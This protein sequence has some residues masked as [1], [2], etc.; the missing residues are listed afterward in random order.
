[1]PYATPAYPAIRDAILRDVAN[2]QPDA[3]VGPDS[4][5]YI[6]AAGIAAAV[7]GLYMH[8]DWLSRQILPDLADA[9][10]LE[11]H[12]SLRGMTRKPAAYA[13]GTLTFSGTPGASIPIGTQARTVAG[14]VYATTL[15]AA[16][17]GAGAATLAAQA[18][19]PGAA[20][21]LVTGASLTLVSAPSGVNGTAIGSAMTGGADIETDAE[22]RTRLI[23]LIRNPPSG[24]AAHDYVRWA[25]EMAGVDLAWCYPLRRGIGTVDVVIMPEGGGIPAPSLVTEVSDYIADLRP[26]T[27]DVLVMGPTA[28]PV[29]ITAALVLTGSVDLADIKAIATVELAAYFA[30]LAPGATAYRSQILAILATQTGVADV[31]LSAP[32][33]NTTTLVDATHVQLATLGA[34]AVT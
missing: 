10:W 20:G 25:G 9:D 34:I 1:M 33:G 14:V 8:Q 5:L 15:A 24:G 17:D 30:G 11:R 12:A 16:L 3:A 19:E 28:V 21:N 29:A 2:Q 26:V 22:L 7:E 27:A 18:V 13:A 31:T 32:A 4:D 23:D 6:R